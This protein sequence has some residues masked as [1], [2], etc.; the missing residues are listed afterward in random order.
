[1]A[2]SLSRVRI[3]DLESTT[4]PYYWCIRT[5]F[6]EGDVFYPVFD[7][8]ESWDPEGD[9]G[10]L[11][12]LNGKADP[13]HEYRLKVRN[14]KLAVTDNG[15]VLYEDVTVDAVFEKEDGTFYEILTDEDNNWEDARAVSVMERLQMITDYWREVFERDG[16]DDSKSPLMVGLNYIMPDETEN[17]A[18]TA[19]EVFPG[20]S[21]GF[22]KVTPN[23][24]V[25]TPMRSFKAV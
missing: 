13:G 15:T 17:A 9:L 8:N 6:L 11:I 23:F 10:Y 12:T 21:M 22:L 3:C 2:D 24:N 5:D 1:M 16:Y 19:L 18:A 20:Y 14:N 25:S 7:E 4:A